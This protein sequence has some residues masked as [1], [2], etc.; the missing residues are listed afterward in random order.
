MPVLRNKRTGAVVSCSEAT[1]ARLGTW[2]EPVESAKQVPRKRA[3]KKK[4]S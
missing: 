3:A 1:V 4:S 2:W